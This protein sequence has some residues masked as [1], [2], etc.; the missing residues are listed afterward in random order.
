MQGLWSCV[1]RQQASLLVIS[2]P[3][4]H[5]WYTW[6]LCQ[7]RAL[8]RMCA[9]SFTRQQTHRQ[10]ALLTVP[11]FSSKITVIPCSRLLCFCTLVQK[12]IS[13]KHRLG[14]T[15]VQIEISA[16]WCHSGKKS[17]CTRLA[18]KKCKWATTICPSEC[19]RPKCR[20]VDAERVLINNGQRLDRV[21]HHW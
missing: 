7:A 12:E 19:H 9:H 8:A 13:Q 17:V 10:N 18:S 5:A 2:F 11:Q 15:L 6:C 21:P 16:H 1:C 20:L 3:K 14:S 4:V